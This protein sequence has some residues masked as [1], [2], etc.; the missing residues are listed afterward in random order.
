MGEIDQLVDHF[1]VYVDPVRDSQLQTTKQARKMSLVR[2][3]LSPVQ[4]STI[5]DRLTGRCVVVNSKGKGER[6]KTHHNK[7]LIIPR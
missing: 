5:K 7:G 4:L 6:A 1:H 3:Q 2:F